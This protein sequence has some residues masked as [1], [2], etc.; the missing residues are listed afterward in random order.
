[1]VAMTPFGVEVV[2]GV[3]VT[4]T[5]SGSVVSPVVFDFNAV[6]LKAEYTIE[7]AGTVP[8][9]FWM[10][11]PPCASWTQLTGLAVNSQLIS[12]VL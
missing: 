11:P 1:M 10:L 5:V 2:D 7:V 8:E 12:T 4:V 3:C 9:V 6:T